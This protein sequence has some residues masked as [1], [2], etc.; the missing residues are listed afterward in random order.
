MS[1][2]EDINENQVVKAE[3]N[4]LPKSRSTQPRSSYLRS[5]SNKVR[6]NAPNFDAA[7]RDV[8]PT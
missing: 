2:V 3:E 1:H 7:W 6:V 4:E 8:Q 5:I